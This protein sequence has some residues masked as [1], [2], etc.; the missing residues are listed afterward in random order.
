MSVPFAP[1]ASNGTQN[2]SGLPAN[3]VVMVPPV[4]AIRYTIDTDSTS[5]LC[6]LKAVVGPE[7]IPDPDSPFPPL[8]DGR[9]ARIV[10]LSVT[11]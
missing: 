10:D 4:L 8:A 9:R 11:S 1:H 3:F 7:L 2:G 6:S 5:P